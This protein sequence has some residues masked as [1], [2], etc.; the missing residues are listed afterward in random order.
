[1]AALVISLPPVPMTGPAPRQKNP[2]PP[3]C[4][5]MLEPEPGTSPPWPQGNMSHAGCV[6][7]LCL[8]T[9][10]VKK[11]EQKQAARQE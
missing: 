6:Q 11:E 1:M 2:C 7:S 10:H 9:L 3:A 4:G 8:K 5:K